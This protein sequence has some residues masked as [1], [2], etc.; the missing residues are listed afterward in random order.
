MLPLSSDPGF[1]EAL[2]Q[3]REDRGL[4]Y[5]QLARLLDISPVMP[6]RY[7]NRDSANF[8]RPNQKTWEALNSVLFRTDSEPD[9]HRVYLD[10]ATTEEVLDELRSRKEPVPFDILLG[11]MRHYTEQGKKR[12]LFDRPPPSPPDLD[13]LTDDE[14]REERKLLASALTWLQGLEMKLPWILELPA[15]YDEI[16][17]RYRQVKDELGRRAM[18]R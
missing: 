18:A 16:G 6:A 4:S 13:S 5:S 2:K 14:L 11:M 1:P 10:A 8:T 3:A 17:D 12:G 7:E 15:F 9:E